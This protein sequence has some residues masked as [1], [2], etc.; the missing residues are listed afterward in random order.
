VRLALTGV[1][2]T[3]LLS[4]CGGDDSTGPDDP[5][6]DVEGVYAIE[7]SFDHLPSSQ[8]SFEGTL[9]LTQPSRESGELEGSISIIV[10]VGDATFPRSDD[11]LSSATVSPSGEISFT[12]GEGESTWTF[13]GTVSGSS[14]IDGRHTLTDGTSDVTGPWSGEAG[15]SAAGRGGLEGRTP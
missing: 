10:T 11:A 15:G 12:A 7:G 9:E 8:A 14:I 13:S 5:F 3:L 4:A 6:P 1:L 2:V